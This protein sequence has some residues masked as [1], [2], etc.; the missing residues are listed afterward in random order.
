VDDYDYNATGDA[1][2]LQHFSTQGTDSTF[3]ASK[4]NTL[5]CL[6]GNLEYAGEEDET[7]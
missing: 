6:K 3:D 4:E 2:A 5:I 7:G 1:E